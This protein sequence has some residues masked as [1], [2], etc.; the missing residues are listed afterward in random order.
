MVKY[1]KTFKQMCMLNG[2]NNVCNDF[3]SISS[4]GNSVVDYCFVSHD[5]LALFEKFNVKRVSR[6]MKLV[7]SHALHL[8]LSQIIRY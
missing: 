1:F 5:K 8:V 6:L 3:T 2:R 4:K 7:L